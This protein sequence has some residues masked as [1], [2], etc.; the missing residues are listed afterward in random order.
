MELVAVFGRFWA[1]DRLLLRRVRAL[2]ALDPDLD[3]ASLEPHLEALAA[4]VQR[5]SESAIREAISALPDG[6]YHSEI[7]NNPLGTKLRYPL[8]VT[9]SGDTI[10]ADF[11][12]AP[13]QQAQGVLN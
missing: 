8:K 3:P 7:W 4:V 12:G 9:V 1:S 2:A 13:P 5:R 10:E 11:E 6:E